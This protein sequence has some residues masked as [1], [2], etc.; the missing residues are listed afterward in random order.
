MHCAGCTRTV[1]LSR[2][3]TALQPRFVLV[4]NSCRRR[5][6]NPLITAHRVD[7]NFNGR[8]ETLEVAEDQTILEVALEQGIELSHDCKMGVCMTCPAKLVRLSWGYMCSACI[9]L[10]ALH[11][12][13]C[14]SK[15]IWLLQ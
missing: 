2:G 4:A 1:R 12:P 13:V 8:T 15:Q 10:V 7:I 6:V 11:T 9:L 5:P 14:M 3:A